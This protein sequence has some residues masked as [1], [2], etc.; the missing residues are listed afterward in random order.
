M[1][2]DKAKH[3]EMLQAAITR[4]A[5]NSFLIKGWTITLVAAIFALAAKDASLRF[6]LVALIPTVFF[7]ALD[8]YYVGLERRFRELYDAVRP[9][10]PAVLPADEWKMTPDRLTAGEWGKTLFRPA[11]VGFYLP[12]LG[13]VVIVAGSLLL[14]P[15]PHSTPPTSADS[16]QAP[17]AARPAPAGAPAVTDSVPPAATPPAPRSD[18]AR[19]DTAGG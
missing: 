1:S 7:W 6:I 9:H 8:A 10:T 11:I 16:T 14:A 4:M 3:L 12:L 19:T 2:Y 18:S 5:S 13:T 17:A 15:S